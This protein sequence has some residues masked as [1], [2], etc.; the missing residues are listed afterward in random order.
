MAAFRKEDP[1]TKG[2]FLLILRLDEGWTALWKC[3]WMKEVTNSSRL[4]RETQQGLPAQ[5]LLHSL[6]SAPP[7]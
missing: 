6:C 3:D 4:S 5:I 2:D 1:K 7:S